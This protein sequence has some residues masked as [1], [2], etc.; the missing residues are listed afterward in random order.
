MQ[1]AQGSSKDLRDEFELVED[2]IQ[3]LNEFPLIVGFDNFNA[4]GSKFVN[5][6]WAG[7]I[8]RVWAV[9]SAANAT[10][11]TVITLELSGVLVTMP[12]LSFGSADPAETVIS[13]IPTALNIVTSGA[14]IEIISDGGGSTI[15]PATIM[16]IVQR[17]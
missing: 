9:N 16:L 12:A 10:A 2:G 5:V 7:K 8:V 17:T 6:P 1:G 13:S 4:A 3:V 14:A 15:M 11:A